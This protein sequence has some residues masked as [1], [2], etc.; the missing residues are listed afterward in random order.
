MFK[1]AYVFVDSSTTPCEFMRLVM[2]IYN[3]TLLV[4]RV[5][6]SKLLFYIVHVLRLHHLLLKTN[7]SSLPCYV[8]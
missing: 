5:H 6:G 8:F 7:I 4:E 3:L 2:L 1:S